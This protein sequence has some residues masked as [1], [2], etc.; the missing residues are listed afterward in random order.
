MYGVL[1]SYSGDGAKKLAARLEERKAEVEALIRGVPGLIS[2]GL[3]RTSDGCTTFTLCK[4]KAGADQSVTIA[5]DWIKK[6]ASDVRASA[7]TITE[8]PVSMRIS[9]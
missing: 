7:P 1:R 9:T 8:G 5:R 2:W 3:M 4:D 6:N